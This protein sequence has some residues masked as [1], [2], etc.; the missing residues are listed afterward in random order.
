[1]T[2]T[3]LISKGNSRSRG[4]RDEDLQEANAHQLAIDRMK[5]SANSGILYVVSVEDP[6][7]TK[8]V[9]TFAVLKLKESSM[10]IDVEGFEVSTLSKLAKIN[11][12]QEALN[13]VESEKSVS[14]KHIRFP[15]TKVISIENKTKQNKK[16]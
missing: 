16:G 14:I 13:Y 7:A 5:Y 12:Y 4:E 9:R 3:V 11:S 8:G 10:T 6:S 1:M 2:N 15:W